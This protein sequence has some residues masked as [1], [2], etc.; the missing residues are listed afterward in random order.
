MCFDMAPSSS[1]YPLIYLPSFPTLSSLSEILLG[2][3]FLKEGC[4]DHKT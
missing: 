1:G 3:G 4:G 2:S